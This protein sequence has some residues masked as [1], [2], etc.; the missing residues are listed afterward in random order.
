MK[1]KFFTAILL[2]FALKGFAQ[3]PSNIDF[4]MGDFSS[5]QCFIGKTYDSSGINV[6]RLNPSAPITNRHT[7]MSSKTDK[8]KYGDFPVLCPFGGN[9]SVKLGNENSGA[10]AEAISYTFNVPAT[11]DTFTFTYFYAVVLEDPNH[12]SWKQPRFFVTAYEVATGNIINCAAFNY[13]AN[14]SLPGFFQSPKSK[15]VLYKNWTPV[16]LQFAGLQ[17]KDVRLEFKNADC[18]LGGHFGYSYLDVS[19]GCSNI[20]ATAPYCIETN[21]LTLNAPYGFQH[22][23]WY[24]ETF[25]TVLGTSQNLTI[26]PAPV[27]SGTFYVDVIPYPGFGCRDT[28][29]A[30]AKPLP[31]P[32]LANAAPDFYFCKNQQNATLNI[33]ADSGNVI[34]WYKNDTLSVGTEL[35]PIIN[36]ATVGSSVYYISQKQLFGC[37]GYRK[38]VT[39]HIVDFTNT[40]IAVNDTKQCLIGNTFTFTSI[41]SNS[42]N[43]KYSWYFG[44]NDSLITNRDTAVSHTYTVPK[45]YYVNLLAN[46]FNQC[47]SRKNITVTVLQAPEAKFT[48]TSPICEKQ[49]PVVFTDVSQPLDGSTINGWWWN[50]NGIV[51]A[52]KQPPNFLPSS[53]S[54][55]VA[56]LIIKTSDGCSSDTTIKKLTVQQRPKAAFAVKTK[57]LCSDEN[58]LIGDSSYFNQTANNDLVNK[59]NWVING[60]NTYVTKDINLVLPAGLNNIRLNVESNFGCKSLLLDTTI[61]VNTKPFMEL[62]INDSCVNVPIFYFAKDTNRLV[63]DWSWDFGNG[64]YKASD[65]VKASYPKVQNLY[66]TVIGTTPAG[67][68]DTIT[69]AFRIYDNIA[70]AGRDTIAAFDQPMQLNANGYPNQ[71][72]LW[73]PNVGLSSDIIENPISLYNNAITYYLHSV[74]QEGCVKD[75]KV[76]IKRYAGPALYVASAF[77]PNGDKLNDVLHVFPVGI[78]QF[79]RFSIYNRLGNLVFTTTD[80][81]EGWDGK[82]KGQLQNNETFVVYAEAIDYRGNPLT[83]KGTVSI[84]R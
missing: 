34:V 64:F 44:D 11:L 76:T 38:K 6:M 26:T 37:E 20:L 1:T 59:W 65:I 83:Y 81:S 32:P 42:S 16:S 31:I 78:K 68:K 36:T 14:G 53:D 40:A 79:I 28:F 22:Y 57:P 45:T 61:L 66:F 35:P 63:N 62:S 72:Y 23:I 5:W 19:S 9:Y 60:A 7:L 18:T 56:K 46:Y 70:F 12:D 84:I 15:D 80:P 75:S 69:R 49:T 47:T 74:T 43:I 51:S 13:V 17:G 27:T 58:V 3:C 39:V 50:I 30:Q 55:I 71:Q 10:E 52:I 48:S 33:L 4:E 24:D 29:Q 8:D 25:T 82:Y 54:P 67:C 41:A 73:K 21:S 77:T 2:L